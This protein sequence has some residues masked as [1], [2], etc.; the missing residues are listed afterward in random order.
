MN[1]SK[2]CAE[3]GSRDVG[4]LEAGK[5]GAR[6]RRSKFPRRM[7]WGLLALLAIILVVSAILI[8]PLFST[9]AGRTAL[10]RVPRGASEAQVRDSVAKYFGDGYAA[11]TLRAMRIIKGDNDLV[12]HGAWLITA[13][14]TPFEAARTLERRGQAPITVPLNSCRTPR[15]V[16]ALLASK[17]EFS[18]QEMLDALGDRGLLRE[19]GTDPEHVLCF[20][21]EDNY[22]FFWTATPGEVIA[23]MHDNYR[24]YWSPGRQDMADDLG[25]STR[26]VVIL[27]SIVDAETNSVSEKGTIARLYLNR[28]HKGMKLQSDPTV[29]Y[30]T[31]DFAARRV[32][33]GMLKA[34]SPYNT[35]MHEGLPPGPIRLTSTAT[36]DA[37]LSSRPND[38][39]YMCADESLDGTHNFAATY[40]E[41]LRNRDRYVNELDRRDIRFPDKPGE[42]VGT[43]T[44]ATK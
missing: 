11:Q 12:R 3:P 5:G 15:D 31:G 4:R 2:Y 22:E 32:G 27:A 28:L 14:M 23:K 39:L 29:K 41:H 10:V 25:L 26:D 40:E 7:L 33:G 20:F 21:L 13:G 6:R 38:F 8:L 44:N 37:I 1:I 35:Y 9:K 36:L 24:R 16:A 34:D 43:A 19:H 17:L 30:A 18:E 42:G